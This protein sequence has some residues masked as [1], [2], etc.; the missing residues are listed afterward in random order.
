MFKGR[1]SDA[2]LS[3]VPSDLKT[4]E[5][6]REVWHW[7]T[8]H[9]ALVQTFHYSRHQGRGGWGSELA[10]VCDSC[11]LWRGHGMNRPV[12]PDSESCITSLPLTQVFNLD[13]L[14]VI[15]VPAKKTVR[16]WLDSVNMDPLAA[17]LEADQ[18]VK[19][20]QDFSDL[21]LAELSTWIRDDR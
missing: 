15:W 11:N 6:W 4:S 16:S 5:D 20:A 21:R 2:R 13:R 17:V 9:V 18:L 7:P 10:P 3:D 19:E 1:I 12:C 14:A 8:P